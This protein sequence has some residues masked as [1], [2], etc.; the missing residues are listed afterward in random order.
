MGLYFHFHLFLVSMYFIQHLV[1]FIIPSFTSILLITS[2]CC[3]VLRVTNFGKPP[4]WWSCLFDI[5][6]CIL[7]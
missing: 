6:I 5:A 1:P 4:F 3:S 2:Y 7:F